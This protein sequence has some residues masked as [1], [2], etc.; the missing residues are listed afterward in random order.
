[1]PAVVRR[2]KDFTKER[3]LASSNAK[4]EVKHDVP[5]PPEIIKENRGRTNL[6]PF[7]DMK[8]GS[9]F[10]V[11]FEGRNPLKLRN[12][13]YFSALG[14]KKRHQM[15]RVQFIIHINEDLQIVEVWRTDDKEITD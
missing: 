7:N 8:I 2:K 12:A 14:W 15:K 9:Y 13:V 10:S 11:P 3:I 5:V 1:M 6:Y 4:Y